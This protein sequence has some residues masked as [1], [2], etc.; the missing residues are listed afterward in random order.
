M[1]GEEVLGFSAFVMSFKEKLVHEFKSL[2]LITLYFAVWVC[3][4]VVLKKLV[5]A[6]YGIHFSALGL[7]VVGVL[8]LAKVVL[9]ME[10]IPVEAWVRNQPAVVPVI[11]R[12]VMYALGVFVVLTI[13]KAFDARHEYGGFTRALT[14]I[15]QHPEY[16]HVL[17]NTI[18]LAWA[19]LG[20]NVLSV[21]RRHFGK[22]G[23]SRLFFSRPSGTDR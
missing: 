11:L 3:M 22:K 13:E 5:L 14:R 9:L 16:P 6:Q 2:G 17:F 20:F 21:L 19:L 10:D 12:T 1:V 7:A 15:Y 23:L 4:I 18:C 8:L